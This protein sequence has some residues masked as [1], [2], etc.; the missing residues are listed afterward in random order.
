LFAL[1]I[2]PRVLACAALAAAVAAC[3]S[4]ERDRAKKTTIPTYDAKTGRLTELT[5]D[6]NKNGT[7]DTWTDMDGRKPLRSRIDLDE[8]GKI[9]RWEYYDD[10]GGLLKVGFSRRQDGTVDAWAFSGP[11]GTVA[12]VEISSTGDERKIDRREFYAGG[13][14]IRVE[15]DSNGD[16]RVDKWETYENGALAT[17]SIDE[18]GDGVADR[19]LS[20]RSGTLVLI[21]SAPDASG[22][23]TKRVEVK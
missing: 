3:S 21:E 19:R 8:D 20:Y 7:I 13:S 9:D 14:L 16:G 17:A 2:V 1:A 15:E 23:F 22:R 12:R 10:K 4:P 18:N 11:D 6:R 5:Y